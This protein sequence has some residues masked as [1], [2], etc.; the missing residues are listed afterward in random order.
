[1]LSRVGKKRRFVFSCIR[2]HCFKR[3]K[4]TLKK[5][6]STAG[7]NALKYIHQRLESL[8]VTAQKGFCEAIPPFN[9]KLQSHP[10]RRNSLTHVRSLLSV[11]DVCYVREDKVLFLDGFVDEVLDGSVQVSFVVGINDFFF[12][13]RHQRG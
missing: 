8:F 1:M 7:N 10:K 9:F 5:Q 2:L 3:L 12:E 6:Q 11:S 13:L 4:T